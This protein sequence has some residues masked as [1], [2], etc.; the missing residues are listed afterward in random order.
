MIDPGH[1]LCQYTNKHWG[2]SI[3]R[4]HGFPYDLFFTYHEVRAVDYKSGKL[5][6]NYYERKNKLDGFF[7][8]LCTIL[9]SFSRR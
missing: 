2:A 3:K 1:K 6:G 9:A 8:V 7:D 5:L 4:H